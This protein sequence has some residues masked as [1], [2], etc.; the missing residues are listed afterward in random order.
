MVMK[1]KSAKRA[2]ANPVPG[3]IDK[4]RARLSVGSLLIGNVPSG[5]WVKRSP[6]R[7]VPGRLVDVLTGLFH[8]TILEH[9]GG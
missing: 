2:T 5:T 4:K 7:L 8:G 1:A 6:G 3:N 9:V